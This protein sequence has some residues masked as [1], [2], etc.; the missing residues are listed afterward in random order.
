MKESNTQKI[1]PRKIF[2]IV[3]DRRILLQLPQ[4]KCPILEEFSKVKN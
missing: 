2:L 3:R 4:E 1:V